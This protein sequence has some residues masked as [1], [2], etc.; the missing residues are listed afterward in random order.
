MEPNLQ[1]V[2]NKTGDHP[3]MS[4]RFD[5]RVAVVTGAGGGLGRVYAL[6]LAR[7]GA[8]VLVNDLGGS[9][10]GTGTG[11]AEAADKVVE[12]IRAS[13]GEA[14]ASYDTV[15]TPQGGE[16]I[17]EK[18]LG[19]FGK[20]DILINNAGI[21]R[22]KTLVNMEPEWWDKVMEV[23]LRGAYNVT[24][25]ALVRM[26]EQAYGRIVMTTSS[27]GLYGNFGQANYAAAKMALVGFMNALKLEGAKYNVLV[28]AVAPMAATRLTQDVLPAEL[29]QRLK[30]EFVAPLVLYL[31]SEQCKD[32]GRIYNA[33]A[34]YFNRAA[35]VTGSGALLGDGRRVPTPEEILENWQAINSMEGAREF[36]NAAASMEPMIRALAEAQ[37]G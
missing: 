35:L 2:D 37:K 12:E 32:S 36:P 1:G 15:S 17:V 19:A 23:H 20:V 33:G 5:G 21:L 9:R 34:G 18:A 25:P 8:K 4:V 28:N 11:S 7:R 14:L 13:G 30:P 22:D 31:C 16:A 29:F 6:E 24:R 27:A 26:R 10:D 3:K